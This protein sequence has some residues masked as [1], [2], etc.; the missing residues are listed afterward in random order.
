MA[1]VYGDVVRRIGRVVIRNLNVVGNNS[2]VIVQSLYPDD[3]LP[4]NRR[5]SFAVS[6]DGIIGRDN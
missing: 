3:G 1:N 6:E 5:K 2:S 4:A